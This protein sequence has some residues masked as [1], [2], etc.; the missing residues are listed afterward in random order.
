M[1]I[2][3]NHDGD[4]PLLVVRKDQDPGHGFDLC[5]GDGPLH[6]EAIDILAG[7]AR[8][9]DLIPVDRQNP[10]ASVIEDGLDRD[11]HHQP[12]RGGFDDAVVDRSYRDL[13]NMNRGRD[14]VAPGIPGNLEVTLAIVGVSADSLPC[15]LGG[16]GASVV[17]CAIDGRRHDRSHAH[18]GHHF[19]R[20][21]SGLYLLIGHQYRQDALNAGAIRGCSRNEHSAVGLGLEETVLINHASTGLSQIRTKNL[22]GHGI[23]TAG[24]D[25]SCSNLEGSAPAIDD[26]GRSRQL[27][28]LKTSTCGGIGRDDQIIQGHGDLLGVGIGHVHFKRSHPGGLGVAQRHL[29]DRTL[30]GDRGVDLLGIGVHVNLKGVPGTSLQLIGEGPIT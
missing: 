1:P 19:N 22:P 14:L 25:Q 29:G 24:A 10:S 18:R 16:Y 28:A 3:R 20:D 17:Q 8:G 12:A 7:V 15:S 5:A 13:G 2:S 11:G 27:Y 6:I 9:L 23:R 21:V 4:D 30:S 26:A